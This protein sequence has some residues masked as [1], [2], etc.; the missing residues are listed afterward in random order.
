[1]TA[2]A[3][4]MRGQ[5]SNATSFGPADERGLGARL[6]PPELD[7]LRSAA[8][9]D[10]VKDSARLQFKSPETIKSHRGTASLKLGARNITQAVSLAIRYGLLR[11]DVEDTSGRSA[12]A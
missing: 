6:T 11:D 9:G 1:M 8:C 2:T 3:S 10:T 5:S 12:T 7:A 4:I